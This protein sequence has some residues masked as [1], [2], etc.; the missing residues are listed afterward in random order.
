MELVGELI[1]DMAAPPVLI[2]P[3]GLSSQ[4]AL[5]RKRAG[6][7]AADIALWRRQALCR[8]NWRLQARLW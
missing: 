3:S 1:K 4:E 6:F 8:L 2:D 7:Q 5:M